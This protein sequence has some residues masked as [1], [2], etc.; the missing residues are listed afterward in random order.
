[1]SCVFICVKANVFY[2]FISLR[3]NRSVLTFEALWHVFFI[4]MA[5]MSKAWCTWCK[6]D[7]ELPVRC[8]NCKSTIHLSVFRR[9]S[10]MLLSSV[11]LRTTEIWPQL[12]PGTEFLKYISFSSF[13]HFTVDIWLIWAGWLPT[14]FPIQASSCI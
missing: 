2:V 11:F 7:I 9:K 13:L 6:T 14:T 12:L 4:W 3:W 5:N 10:S 1:M 8:K